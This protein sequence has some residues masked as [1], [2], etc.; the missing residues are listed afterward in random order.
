[1]IWSNCKHNWC[2]KLMRRSENSQIQRSFIESKWCATVPIQHYCKHVW[3]QI[4]FSL[5]SQPEQIIFSLSSQP[6]RNPF[7]HYH[8]PITCITKCWKW[9]LKAIRIPWHFC[10][11]TSQLIRHGGPNVFRSK[12][13]DSRYDQ[14]RLRL[15]NSG[16]SICRI[17]WLTF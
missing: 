15:D 1:M 10:P 8:W 7:W 9:K 12:D 11:R 16:I 17:N 5:S 3:Q 6:E 2:L 4:I 14:W 13:T